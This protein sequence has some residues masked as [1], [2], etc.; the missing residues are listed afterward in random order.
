MS[1]HSQLINLPWTEEHEAFC[2]QHQITPAAKTLWQWL[3]R[4]GE[5]SSEIEPNLAEF[6]EWVAKVRGKGYSTNL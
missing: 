6:N 2:Y 1:E 4:Q 3:M 5:I